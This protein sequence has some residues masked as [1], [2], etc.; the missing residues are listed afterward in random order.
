MGNF[1][2][3]GKDGAGVNSG[4]LGEKGFVEEKFPGDRAVNKPKGPDEKS[5]GVMKGSVKTSKGSFNWK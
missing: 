2:Y 5:P 1:K 4:A 3:P